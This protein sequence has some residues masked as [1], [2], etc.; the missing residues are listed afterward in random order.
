MDVVLG[1]GGVCGGVCGG[2]DDTIVEMVVGRNRF[3]F[4]ALAMKKD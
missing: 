2:K 1:G 3:F 4:V